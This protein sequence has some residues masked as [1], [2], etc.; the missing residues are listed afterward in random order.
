[1]QASHL[2]PPLE[3]RRRDLHPTGIHPREVSGISQIEARLAAA[4]FC[5]GW[6]GYPIEALVDR[7]E[8][9][10][11]IPVTSFMADGAY[12]QDGVYAAVAARHPEAI[13][14]VP[15]R[16]SAVPSNTADAAPSQRDRHLQVIV[17]HGRTAW[18]VTSGYR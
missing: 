6:F 18:Q 1:M 10:V 14:V 12:G 5:A 15:P 16:S 9:E 11:T 8:R 4:P 13:V 3:F 2:N 7:W 17:E